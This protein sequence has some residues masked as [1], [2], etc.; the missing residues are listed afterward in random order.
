MGILIETEDIQENPT[1]DGLPNIHW[2][3]Q[4]GTK[5]IQPLMT[6]AQLP[7]E[8]K[9]ANRNRETTNEHFG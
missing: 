5:P 2:L 6:I 8:D 7:Q 9:E 4:R 3:S 1:L